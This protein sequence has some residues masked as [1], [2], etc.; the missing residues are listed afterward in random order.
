MQE[1]NLKLEPINS[2]SKSELP[3]M[4]EGKKNPKV[5][6]LTNWPSNPLPGG[7]LGPLPDSLIF[8]PLQGSI[9]LQDL[10]DGLLLLLCQEA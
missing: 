9:P 10:H 2:G 4:V 5:S 7:P 6:H 1:V 8:N 3:L